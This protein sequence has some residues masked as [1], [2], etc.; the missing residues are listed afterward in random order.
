MFSRAIFGTE[1]LMAD[2]DHL[3]GAMVITIAVCATAEVARPLRFL[4]I[5]LG[6]WL[7]AAPQGYRIWRCRL[8]AGVAV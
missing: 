6:L 8:I 1:G 2:N 5:L 3:I 7:V 4:N